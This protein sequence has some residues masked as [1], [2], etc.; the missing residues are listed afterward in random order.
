MLEQSSQA[1]GFHQQQKLERERKLILLAI[2]NYHN[3][4]LSQDVD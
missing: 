2:M 3:H 1:I 4:Q